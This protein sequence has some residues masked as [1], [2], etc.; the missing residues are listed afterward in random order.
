MPSDAGR[1]RPRH[2]FLDHP[3]PIPF[4]HRGGAGDHPENTLVAFESAIRLGYRYVET[5]VHA[6]ADGVLLAFHDDRLDRVTDRS[7][8]VARLAY[9]DVAVALVDRR[10]PIPRLEELLGA[11]PDV[12]VNIDPK[13]DAAVDPLIEVIRRSGAIDRVCVGSFSGR[14]IA[15]VRAALGPRLCT[16]LGPRGVLA[17][18]GFSW[19]GPGL[20]RFVRSEGAA[21]VQV[22]V[23]QGWLS[24]VDDRL[25]RTAHRLGLPVHVWTVDEPSEMSRLLDLGVDGL[26]TDRP[27]VLR[28]VLLARGAWA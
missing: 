10:E 5:D 8:I 1:P 7:G 3:G 2:A 23:R 14:R 27:V 19:Q 11:F 21:C 4:A 15:R 13:H 28:D 20:E 24:I 18:R 26:M 12:R 16:S 17:L 25:L 9:A 6:T 22:P